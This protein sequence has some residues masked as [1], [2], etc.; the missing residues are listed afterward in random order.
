MFD[1]KKGYRLLLFFRWLV[2]LIGKYAYFIGLKYI[3][4]SKASIIINTNPLVVV[5]IAYFLL[6]EVLTKLQI[7]ALIGAFLGVV[8]LSYNK[9]EGLNGEDEY[10]YLGIA[11]ALLWWLCTAGVNIKLR[12]LGPHVHPGLSPV[13][14]SISTII[15]VIGFLTFYPSIYNFSEYTI[16]DFTWFTLSGILIYVG[17]HFMSLAFKY[18]DAAFVSSFQYLNVIILTVFDIGVFHYSFSLTD[19]IGFVILWLWVCAPIIADIYYHNK[20]K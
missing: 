8:V 20:E 10:Y 11:L 16:Y 4:V 5:P 18:E 9:N 7:I 15:S 17:L 14:Y 12:V 19:I 13:W 2:E 3:P 1:V 6:K